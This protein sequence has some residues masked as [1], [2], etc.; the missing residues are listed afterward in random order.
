M[1]R[2]V[3]IGICLALLLLSLSACGAPA[4]P[5]KASAPAGSDLSLEE[6]A[7]R[8]PEE[9]REW[10][11]SVHGAAYLAGNTDAPMC[12][13]CHGD[14]ASGEMETAAFRL[15]I[16]AQCARCHDDPALTAKYHLP[17]DVYTSYLADY[18]GTTIEY[19]RANAPAVARYE[20]VCSD[21]HGSHAIYKPDDS[22]SSVAP[23]NL[24]ATCRKCHQGAEAS[25]AT[26]M[27]G[28]FRTS[29][30]AAPLSHYVQLV[31]RILIPLIIGL[32]VLYIVLDI[33]YRLR[34]RVARGGRS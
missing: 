27:A 11:S 16:P 8:Y 1:K 28:H 24:L 3:C 13:G 4:A 15:G 26:A 6:W 10:A 14:P 23:G 17:A 7:K 12:T 19:Y 5:A 33:I 21:C 2:L 20:A 25:F 34:K 18:H 30:A 29:L 31:Y 9:Y 32:M 22:R